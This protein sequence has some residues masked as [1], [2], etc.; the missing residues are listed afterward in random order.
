MYAQSSF[1]TGWTVTGSL[2]VGLLFSSHFMLVSLHS[3]SFISVAKYTLASAWW[4]MAQ[5]S[6]SWQPGRSI[7]Y[8]TL[9]RANN[10][11]STTTQEVDDIFTCYL[12]H[13]ALIYPRISLG[14]CLAL[15]VCTPQYVVCTG[16]SLDT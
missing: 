13:L 2:P 6:Y 16:R 15:R 14:Q 5:V 7:R 10:P 12:S 11:Q 4:P 3:L 9:T 8:V 1:F